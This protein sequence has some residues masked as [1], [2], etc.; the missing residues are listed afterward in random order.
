MKSKIS[1]QELRSLYHNLSRALGFVWDSGPK[2]MMANISIF[3]IQGTIPL[4]ALYLIKLVIDALTEALAQPTPTAAFEDI[5]WLIMGAGVLGLIVAIIG[6]FGTFVQRAQTRAVSDHMH[7]ILHTKS[8]EVDL[9]YY[10]NPEY[11]N[12]LHRA[13]QAASVRPQA[14]LSAILGIGQNTIAFVAVMGLLIWLE[15][16]IIPILLLATLP[17]ILVRI[18]FAG[19][20]HSW[21]HRSE[22]RRVGKE[23]RSRWSPYH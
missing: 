5:S 3:L 22:E 23:C 20:M 2:W 17:E 11:F 12:T 6:I 15:W 16:M 13:Q 18:H 9:E 19:K 21:E 4:I 8:V 14:I 10:E 7:S 1:S